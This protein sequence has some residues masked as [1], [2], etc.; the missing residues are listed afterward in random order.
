MDFTNFKALLG[1]TS[2][3]LL[4]FIFKKWR[5]HEYD[6]FPL[7]QNQAF[8]IF[9]FC[10]SEMSNAPLACLN[11]ALHSNSRG[12]NSIFYKAA[13]ESGVYGLMVLSMQSQSCSTFE[14]LL[15]SPGG[16]ST[17]SFV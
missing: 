4:F 15:Y 14:N 7:L 10:F 6:F 12:L 5:D 13:N 3:G 16:A 8:S 2:A 11:S 1:A 9:A 17:G